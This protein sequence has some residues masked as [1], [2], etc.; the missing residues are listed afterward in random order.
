VNKLTAAGML[1]TSP[2]AETGLAILILIQV[3]E[4]ELRA[5]HFHATHGFKYQF[6]KYRLYPELAHQ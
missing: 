2:A 3:L 6:F 4:A 1:S 5:V